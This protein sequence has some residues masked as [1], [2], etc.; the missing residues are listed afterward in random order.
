[1]NLGDDDGGEDTSFSR[2]SSTEEDD[3]ESVFEVAPW[4]ESILA[5]GG[6]TA[7][8][9]AFSSQ[10]LETGDVLFDGRPSCAA[11]RAHARAH[12]LTATARR[13]PPPHAARFRALAR[14]SAQRWVCR[15]PAA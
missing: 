8:D 3:Q 7:A 14:R 9:K 10:K 1:M 13:Q 5:D 11:A 4:L 12:A 6:R 15:A 2:N